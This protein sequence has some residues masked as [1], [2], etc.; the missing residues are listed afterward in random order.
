MYKE[1]GEVVCDMHYGLPTTTGY[2]DE[3]PIETRI[4][5]RVDM[6]TGSSKVLKAMLNGLLFKHRPTSNKMAVVVGY[7]FEG[8][9]VAAYSYD[10]RTFGMFQ[11]RITPKAAKSECTNGQYWDMLSGYGK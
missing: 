11:F 7:S 3:N 8:W 10:D 5:T 1:I 2:P 6:I 4:H 9:H